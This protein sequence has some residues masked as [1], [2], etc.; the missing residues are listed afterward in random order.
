VVVAIT[1]CMLNAGSAISLALLTLFTGAGLLLAPPKCQLP[2]FLRWCFLLCVVASAFSLLPASWFGELPKWRQSLV[3]DWGIPLTNSLSPQPA[4]SLGG[5]LTLVTAGCWFFLILGSRLTESSRRLTLRGIT[6][7]IYLI[8]A[9][10]LAQKFGWLNLHWP[11]GSPPN[12]IDLGPFSNRNHFS[13]LCAIGCVLGAGMAHDAL[14]QKSR[15]FLLYAAGILI[16]F[17]GIVINSSRAGL[18]LFFVGLTLWLSTGS[19]RHGFFRKLAVTASL[20]FGAASILIVF[21]GGSGARLVDTGLDQAIG[22]GRLPIYYQ[23]MALASQAPLTGIGIGN[24]HSVF[25]LTHTVPISTARIIHPESDWLWCWIELGLV[26]LLPL[27][28]ALLWLLFVSFPSSDSQKQRRHH[29]HDRR[30]RT[31]ACIGFLLAVL[32][33][34]VDVPLHRFGF[35]AVVLLLAACAI[36][37]RKLKNDSHLASRLSF[38]AL[39][40]CL[41]ALGSTQVLA[42]REQSLFTNES[43]TSIR[44]KQIQALVSSGKQFEALQACNR[45]LHFTPLDWSLYFQRGVLKLQLRKPS[46]DA[47]D[48]FNR[49]RVLEPK[50]INICQEEAAL[51]LKFEPNMAI[52][53]WRSLL[54]RSSNA[55]SYSSML[56]LSRPHPTLALNVRKLATTPA[57]LAAILSNSPSGPDWSTT[58]KNL[59]DLDPNLSKIEHEQRKQI[60]SLWQQRVDRDQLVALLESHPEW[61]AD[62]WPLLAEEYARKT[63][64]EKAWNVQ[65]K[66]A[67]AS[68][69]QDVS[70]GAL[71]ENLERNFALK[72]TDARLGVD[73]Y[74]AQKKRGLLDDALRTLDR[75]QELPDPPS[76]LNL[77][78]AALFAERKDFRRAYETMKSALAAK[79]K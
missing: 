51:W 41:L 2:A 25:A 4:L 22:S 54:E 3:D 1:A 14:S 33:G 53:P 21:G 61:H 10:A 23:A 50:N 31:V 52:V 34:L 77:E 24:F 66:H 75:L 26:G 46:A 59:L 17:T 71:F 78:K 56:Q 40:L 63:E 57:M 72:P 76:F 45:A 13:S 73:L 28:L 55:G 8:A 37:S 20:V 44:K 65:R 27:A 60:L 58:L 35:S 19:V 11:L 67:Y 43:S 5:L 18:L 68:S 12:P 70:S 42:L 16:P 29:V 36:P 64:F 9:L 7:G 6:I 39:G 32:H 49:A 47:L 74:F 30:L 62:S 48:D 69:P 38:R 79:P 15:S